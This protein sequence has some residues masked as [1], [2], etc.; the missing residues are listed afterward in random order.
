MAHTE[1]DGFFKS[2]FCNS[3]GACVEVNTQQASDGVVR[4]RDAA[5]TEITVET[6]AFAGFIAAVKAGDFDQ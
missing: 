3:G 5:H 2:S 1:P 4:M 6:G